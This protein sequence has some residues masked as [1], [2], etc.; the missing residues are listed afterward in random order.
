MQSRVRSLRERE[1]NEGDSVQTINSITLSP[2]A[3]FQHFHFQFHFN[4]SLPQRNTEEQFRVYCGHKSFGL[5]RRA[6]PKSKP[7]SGVEKFQ[8]Q[9]T[10]KKSE[11]V[12]AIAIQ[13]EDV[14]I[15][16]DIVAGLIFPTTIRRIQ[17]L[18]DVT[19][20][21]WSIFNL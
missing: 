17:V 7:P 21:S 20:G 5:R 3:V 13:K 16:L 11:N 8:R 12:D 14:F 2:H 10:S 1:R 4:F 15:M 18:P 19:Y 6:E 9:M